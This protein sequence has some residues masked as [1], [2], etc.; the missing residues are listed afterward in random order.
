[1][2]RILPKIVFAA[3]S[4]L[5]IATAQADEIK[6]RLVVSSPGSEI[7]L[8]LPQNTPV[9]V[10]W[11]TGEA[12]TYRDSV[13]TGMAEGDTITVTGNSL[14]TGF[15]CHKQN[16]KWIDLSEATGLISLNCAGNKIET[17]TIPSGSMLEELD[18]SNNKLSTLNVAGATSLR[19][20][21]CS[22]NNLSESSMNIITNANL[23]V[24]NISNN[25]FNSVSLGSKHKLRSLWAENNS[26][27]RLTF[28]GSAPM[29]SIV[30]PGNQ[31]AGVTVSKKENLQ[32]YWLG[33]NA[34][35]KILDLSACSS[36]KTLS[37]KG[38]GID[39]L[40]LSTS[41]T[42]T[43]P[44]IFADVSDNHLSM[45]GFYN[46]NVVKTYV[47]GNQ[48]DVNISENDT[49]QAGAYLDLSR[50]TTNAGG[51]R[52]GALKFYDGETDEALKSGS[53]AKTGDYYLMTSLGRAKFFRCIPSVYLTATSTTYP[54]LLITTKK[55]VV[56]DEDIY[57]GIDD[58]TTDADVE[59]SVDGGTLTLAAAKAQQT[60]VVST[61]GV[62]M[63][64]GKI[65]PEAVSLSLAPGIYIVGQKKIV[66]K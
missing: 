56:Y 14:L 9:S 19:Y 52:V 54:D 27:A 34:T 57:V 12:Q 26:L 22:G 8:G 62:V 23:E 45:R 42:S 36:L 32:D 15:D 3:V 43:D 61:D 17:I 11:G 20:L 5:G 66:V 16:I 28:S 7:T 63:W 64:Q 1:M 46:T 25:S 29:Q 58:V 18:C 55:F 38:L 6:I 41:L 10:H 48:T 2:N 35:Q 59:Y 51:R 53:S 39:S 21:D 30:A 47:C 65:G 50:F 13:V 4:C 31:I 40:V 33:G 49:L 37:V 44:V 24:L 60:S